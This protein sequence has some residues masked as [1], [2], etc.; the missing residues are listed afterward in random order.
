MSR[1]GWGEESHGVLRTHLKI[2]SAGLIEAKAD[3]EKLSDPVLDAAVV[4]PVKYVF[5]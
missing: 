1:R 3:K 5:T 2:F 4:S